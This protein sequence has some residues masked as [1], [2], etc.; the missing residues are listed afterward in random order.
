MRFSGKVAL[1]TG[2]ANG[3]GET[4]ARMFATEGAQVVIADVLEAE[5]HKVVADISAAGGEAAFMR[6]D[7]TNEEDWKEA[8]TTTVARFGKLDILVNNAGITRTC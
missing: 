2:G 3:M 7:V 5:G 8:V 4:E 1:I 6:L